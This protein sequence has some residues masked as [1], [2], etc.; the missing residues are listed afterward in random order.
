MQI[1][2]TVQVTVRHSVDCKDREKGPN[3]PRCNCRKTLCIYQNG[4]QKRISAQ[5]RSWKEAEHEAQRYRDKFDPKAQELERL[6]TAEEQKHLP[7]EKSIAAYL[8]DMIHRLGDNGTVSAA[9]NLLEHSLLE[10][11]AKL[12]P[13]ER[14]NYIS[15]ITPIHLMAWRA[16]WKLADLTAAIRWVNVKTFF[17]FCEAQ[18]WIPDSPARRIRAPKVAR[19]GRTAIF[20]DAQYAAIIDAASGQQR[21]T[22]FIELLRWSGMALADAVQFRLDMIDS[23]GV[24]RYRRHKT[25]TLATVP[26]PERVI[27]LL[28]DVPLAPDSVGPDQPFRTKGIEIIKSDVRR[29]QRELNRIFEQ[30]GITE[31]QTESGRIRKPHPHMFRDTCAVSAL[32]HGAAIHTVA[33]MLGHTKIETT[34]TAYMPYCKE[35]EDAQIADARAAQSAA[36][37][38]PIKGRKVL[39]MGSR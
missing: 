16:S 33:R 39:K 13:A 20:T 4:K 34:Q 35:L 19:G 24:L 25:E 27:V 31:V 11:L 30:A 5:T 8:T 32:R 21:L 6:R 23:E 17:N 12:T 3:W 2:P 36:Q 7:I 1:I 37:P 9:R 38:K 15:E 18:R 26:L 22:T 29:W 10:W 28:R 14:P